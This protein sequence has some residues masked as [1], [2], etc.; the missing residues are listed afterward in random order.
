LARLAGISPDT[1]RHYERMEVL[2]RPQRS[3]GNYR[4]YPPNAL[5]RLQLIRR[6][7]AAGFS[8]PEL[9]RIFK[10]RD[11]GGAPCR[12]VKRLLEEKLERVDEQISDLITMRDHLRATLA[13]W[14]ARLA[15][16]PDGAQARLLESLQPGPRLPKKSP[17]KGSTA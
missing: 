1:L 16:T 7:L 15:K 17:L 2:P 8:L 13:D 3:D 14:D 6:A 9:A 4:L 12:Q 5:D 10:I 11:Q